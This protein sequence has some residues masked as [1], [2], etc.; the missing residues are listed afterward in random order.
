M[1]HGPP[2]Q[3]QCERIGDNQANIVISD[4]S[5]SCLLY[6]YIS[7]L[8]WAMLSWTLY[9]SMFGPEYRYHVIV[10]TWKNSCWW[11]VSNML[12]IQQLF[13]TEIQGYHHTCFTRVPGRSNACKPDYTTWLLLANTAC[14]QCDEFDPI[15]LHIPW[16]LLD[17]LQ[18]PIVLVSLLHLLLNIHS[19]VWSCV[20]VKTL[21]IHPS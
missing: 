1:E 4:P 20:L 6:L 11:Q 2:F 8:V 15:S 9:L 10:S 14:A 16:S 12:F 13:L 21:L 3:R 7:T 18:H 17:P 19:S 5:W